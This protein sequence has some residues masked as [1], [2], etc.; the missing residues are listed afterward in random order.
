MRS[1]VLNPPEGVILLLR[2]CFCFRAFLRGSYIIYSKFI[3]INSIDSGIYTTV[4]SILSL[5]A[6]LANHSDIQR[7]IH[8]EIDEVVGANEPT[9][10]DRHNMH[11]LS[12][13]CTC[14]FSKQ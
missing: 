12:A 1:T 6:T 9:L 5:I 10:Q 4:A 3:S 7:N 2:I 8:K 11:Y 13:V 14:T